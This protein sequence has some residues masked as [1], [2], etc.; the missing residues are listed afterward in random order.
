MV[1]PAVDVCSCHGGYSVGQSSGDTPQ[2]APGASCWIFPALDAAAVEQAVAATAV[3]VQAAPAA[4][5][6]A[7]GTLSVC[8]EQGSALGAGRVCWQ[9]SRTHLLFFY[10]LFL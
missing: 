2:L 5:A 8:S 10:R 6:T 7:V 1:L 3:D 9:P 4:G